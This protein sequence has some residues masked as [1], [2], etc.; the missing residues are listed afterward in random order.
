ML[1]LFY[2]D[3]DLSDNVFPLAKSTYR[4]IRQCFDY[5]SFYNDFYF[6]TGLYNYYR[7]AYP[8]THPIY[9]ILAFLFPK[10][11][12]AKGLREMLIS[13]RN[14]I[15]LKGESY[16]F[17]SHIYMHYENDYQQA[18]DFSRSLHELYPANLQYLGSY[19]KNIFL[20]KKYDEAENII[21]SSEGNLMNPYF[22]A[23]L[24]IFN[25]IL[26]E[27]KYHN[28]AEAKKLYTKGISNF[29]AYGYYGNDYTSY[30]YFG[31][32]RICDIDKDKSGKKAYRKKAIEL[33]N[34]KKINFDD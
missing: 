33:T 19:L 7:E 24:T 25:G 31:L 23:Q 22:Q 4:Y 18:Y 9:K 2:A 32:S 27:K 13:A 10:G 17:L 3:N 21:R 14:S 26:Q 28:Y 29:A 11:D 12:R 16:S 5:S 15:M 34:Y 6:F 30:A 8:D 1:L 20:T